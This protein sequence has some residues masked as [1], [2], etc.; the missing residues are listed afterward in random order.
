MRG[1]AYRDLIGHTRQTDIHGAAIKFLNAEGL[2]G[3]KEP[4]TREKDQIDVAT[5][6]RLKNT[7]PEPPAV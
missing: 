6:R 7:E 2:I 1:Q 3:L 4:S 5:L